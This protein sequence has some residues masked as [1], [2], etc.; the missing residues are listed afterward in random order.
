ME[1]EEVQIA[2]ETKDEREGKDVN[3]GVEGTNSNGHGKEIDKEGH[4]MKLIEKLQKGAQAR[5]DDSRKLMKI[6]DR[7]GE[8][9]LKMLKSLEGI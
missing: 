6:R 8:F 5:I 4:M 1:L 7:H 9:N 2:F 3:P